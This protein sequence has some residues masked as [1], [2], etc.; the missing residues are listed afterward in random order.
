MSVLDRIKTTLEGMLQDEDCLSVREPCLQGSRSEF[1]SPKRLSLHK[2]LLENL[3]GYV[4][5]IDKAAFSLSHTKT[6]ENLIYKILVDILA[7]DLP[8]RGIRVHEVHGEKVFRHAGIDALQCPRDRVACVLQ[9]FFVTGVCYVN[10][11]FFPDIPVEKAFAHHLA[12]LSHP[13]AVAQA[14]P[15]CISAVMT[16]FSPDRSFVA[17]SSL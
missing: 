15:I 1:R 3:R 9:G 6:G 7:G 13:Q 4:L 11:L 14:S 17:S 8:E 2:E 16:T 10:L 5:Y 12:E